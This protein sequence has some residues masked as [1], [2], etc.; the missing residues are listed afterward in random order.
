[1]RVFLLVALA[2]AVPV[3]TR[4][5]TILDAPNGGETFFSGET[6]TI[7]WHIA[8]LHGITGWNLDYALD[9]PEPN[10]WCSDQPAYDWVPIVEGIPPT[11]DD[12]HGNCAMPADPDGCF[13]EYEWTIPEALSAGHMKI[14]VVMETKLHAYYDVSN[15]SF[16][17]V[18]KVPLARRSWSRIKA[19]YR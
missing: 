12:Q 6:I 7:R 16:R 15:T 9:A 14:R 2:L 4:A 11:C 18:G 19:E 17:V 5:H 3:T 8:I 13:I 10:D 1:M